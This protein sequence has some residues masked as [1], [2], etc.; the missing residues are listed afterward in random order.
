MVAP[1]VSP[2]V[3]NGSYIRTF[4]VSGLLADNQDSLATA[5]GCARTPI[6]WKIVDTSAA[7]GTEGD[8]WTVH[9]VG[10]TNFT[11]RK[12]T[13]T[14]NRTALITFYDPHSVFL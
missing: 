9:T 5:H 6:A 4:T 8:C 11:V 14:N 13:T 7:A 1:V 12:L 10:A 3:F 2:V